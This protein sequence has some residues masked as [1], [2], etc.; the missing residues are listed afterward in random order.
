MFGEFLVEV[1]ILKLRIVLVHTFI[2]YLAFPTSSPCQGG[3]GEYH[4]A[5]K[6]Q[7]RSSQSIP[8][9]WSNNIGGPFDPCCHIPYD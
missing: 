8:I 9:V 6:K 1:G 4:A 5:T 7:E 3:K 2:G